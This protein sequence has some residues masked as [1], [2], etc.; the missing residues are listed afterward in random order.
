MS[1]FHVDQ[2]KILA[3]GGALAPGYILKPGNQVKPVVQNFTTRSNAPTVRPSVSKKI[4]SNPL[5]GPQKSQTINL[6]NNYN[7]WAQ[8]PVLNEI[9]NS[10]IKLPY[11]HLK[12]YRLDGS[13][14]WEQYKYFSF[15]RFFE[16]VPDA[17]DDV[18]DRNKYIQTIFQGLENIA[19]GIYDKF[20]EW[21]EGVLP[22][23]LP[24]RI[25]ATLEDPYE[26]LYSLTQTGFEYIFPFFNK[27]VFRKG[28]MY[29]ETYSGESQQGRFIA[30]DL[31]TIEGITSQHSQGFRAL[32]EPGLYI[33]KSQFY[34]FGENLEEIRF[35]FPLLNTQSQ[36]QIDQNFQLIFLLVFQ[37]SMYRKDRAAFIPPCIYEVLIPG[38]RYMKYAHVSSLEVDF[39]GVRRMERV[40]TQT[41]RG[42]V[43]VKTIIPEA[44]NVTL[45]MRGLHEETA[46][47]MFRSGA[48]TFGDVQYLSKLEGK[49]N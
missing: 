23:D 29:S 32:A 10:Q 46:N 19:G 42:P 14:L 39:L 41:I 47:F 5:Q 43:K 7:N 1:I 25:N 12:E 28:S 21:V 40:N 34:E 11:I 26:G 9:Y 3:A 13:T 4:N 33:E 48:N 30:E 20:K 35:S 38:I 37:N 44:Y 18:F 45:T 15:Y 31:E 22:L 36:E 2:L 6:L 27:E 8:S 49:V 24:D 16:R 17:I